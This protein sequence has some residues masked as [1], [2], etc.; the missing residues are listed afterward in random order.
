V[1]RRILRIG[2]AALAAF[3]VVQL[4]EWNIAQ[5]WQEWCAMGGLAISLWVSGGGPWARD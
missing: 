3:L 1:I 2:N 5:G 4:C